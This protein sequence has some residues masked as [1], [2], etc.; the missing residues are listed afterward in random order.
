MI[1]IGHITIQ[2][3]CHATEKE[4]SVL[5]ALKK[6]YPTFEKRTVTGYFGN[7]I[8]IFEATITRTKEIASVVNMMKEHFA[9]QLKDDL[10]RRIDKKGNLYIRVDKQELYHGNFV[11]KDSGEVKITIHI[12]SYPFRVED[13]IRYAEE[14][15]GH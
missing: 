13:A 10:K 11:A 7:P 15:F 1:E 6:L 9:A 14:L 4:E 3:L 8:S 5:K 2:T 12:Q